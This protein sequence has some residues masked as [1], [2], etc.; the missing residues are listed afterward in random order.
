MGIMSGAVQTSIFSLWMEIRADKTKLMNNNTVGISID[1][2]VNGENLAKVDH[3]CP[4]LVTR[5]LLSFF[6]LCSTTV[7]SGVEVWNSLTKSG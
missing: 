6:I 2:K 5:S 3:K 7:L 4:A 1:I